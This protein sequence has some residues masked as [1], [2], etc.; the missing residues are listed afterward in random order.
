VSDRERL[1]FEHLVQVARSRDDVVGLYLF[2]SRG[3]GLM[4]DARSDWDICVVLRDRGAKSRFKREYPYLHGAELEIVCATLDDLRR[5]D[6]IGTAA[7]QERYAAAHV[8]VVIDKTEGELSEIVAAK[9]WIPPADRDR[10]IRAALDQYINSTYR[11][12]RYGSRLDAA[13]SVPALLRTIFALA[14]RIRP[15]NKYLEWE[16]RQHPLAGWDADELLAL[17]DGVIAG[18]EEVQHT[19]FRRVESAARQ[20]GYGDVADAWEPD[21]AWLRGHAEYRSHSAGATESQ[22]R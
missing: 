1:S 2:G 5:D 11:S 20:G 21:L 3:R 6:E 7:E 18:H 15:F 12:L 14:G 8:D 4:V 17:V 10:V 9:E 13:E 16:L 22:H 19:L